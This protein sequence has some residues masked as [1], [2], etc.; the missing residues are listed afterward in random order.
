ML[1]HLG[2]PRTRLLVFHQGAEQWIH[3]DLLHGGSNLGVGA[4]PTGFTT[5]LV[6]WVD[7]PMQNG[8]IYIAMLDEQGL[9]LYIYI[10][11]YIYMCVYIYCKILL[12]YRIF[13]HIKP[14][15]IIIIFNIYI[16]YKWANTT[17][18]HIHINIIILYNSILLLSRSL[19]ALVSPPSVVPH[20]ALSF[21]T[22]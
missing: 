18:T 13:N 6:R 16:I 4:V 15:W 21:H 11:M 3:H 17:H 5:P 20:R 9:S 22:S 12:K 7:L 1:R 8:E 10:Y 19:A 2:F 14:Y